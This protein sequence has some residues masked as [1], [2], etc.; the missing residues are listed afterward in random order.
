[1]QKSFFLLAGLLLFFALVAPAQ[2]NNCVPVRGIAQEHLLDF[3]NPDWVGGR[4]GDPWV[5]PVQLVLGKNEVL[6]GKIS[7]N[8]GSAG[9]SNGTGQG[10][11]GSYLFDFGADGTF[12]V[13]YGNA[14]WPN[15]PRFNSAMTGTFHASGSVDVSA[16]TGRFANASGNIMT[17]GPFAAW[18]FVP[19]P[20]PPSGR[21][22]NSITGF[23]CNVA[24]KAE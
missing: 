22:N 3:E 18:S 24:P 17:D 5:G 21:F 7:E 8:D 15:L 13:R 19:P 9:P 23:L 1:M 20:A 6:I 16:G 10:R 11:N 14:V 2:N 4:P 12:I